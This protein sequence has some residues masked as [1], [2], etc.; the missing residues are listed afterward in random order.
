MFHSSEGGGRRLYPIDYD[1][2]SSNPVFMN[3]LKNLKNL[4]TYDSRTLR[5]K[6][7]QVEEVIEMIELELAK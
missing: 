1:A 6:R 5:D 4:N 2:L 3:T 7:K